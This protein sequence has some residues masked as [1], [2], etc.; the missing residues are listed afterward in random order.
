MRTQPKVL[1]VINMMMYTSDM[2]ISLLL[3]DGPEQLPW[4]PV[5]LVRNLTMMMMLI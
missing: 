5:P 2:Y 4:V 3:A 1:L